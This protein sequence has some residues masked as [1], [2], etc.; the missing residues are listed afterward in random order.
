MLPR[1]I[2]SNDISHA[3]GMALSLDDYRWLIGPEAAKWLARAAADTRSLPARLSRLRGSIGAERARLVLEQVE[4]RARARAKFSQ[5]DRMFFTRVGLEQA[6]DEWIA[7]YK[8]RRFPSRQPVAD[9]C[10]GLGGDLMALARRGPAIGAERDETTALLA[11]ENVRAAGVEICRVERGWWTG[12]DAGLLATRGESGTTIVVAEATQC[13][14]AELAA[15]HIDPDRRPQGRRT[16]RV[17]RHE[18]D[19]P[20]IERL[21]SINPHAAIKLA[22]ACQPPDAWRPE[23]ELE[24]ISR[25][26][27]CR[28]LVAWFGRLAEHPGLRRATVLESRQPEA[29]SR[30]S[31]VGDAALEPPVAD[32]LGRYVFDP[33]PAVVAAGLVGVVAARHALSAIAARA[34]YLTGDHPATDAALACFEVT[35]ALPFDLKRLKSVLRARGIGRLEIKKRGVSEDPE[36]LRRRL[37]LRGDLAAVLVLARVGR[38]VTA[39][40]ARRIGPEAGP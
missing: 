33:D 5:A 24:W 39:I 32:R 1:S 7:A 29:S 13:P 15:W 28:Q 11:A 30:R 23:A 2:R 31:V 6:S 14:L 25:D 35:D 17:D 9:L 40:V 4:L 12:G 26:R 20:A 3:I 19:L 10:C 8:A 37:A 38:S 34:A 21:R 16:T 22:P 18:P 27:Q 36:S